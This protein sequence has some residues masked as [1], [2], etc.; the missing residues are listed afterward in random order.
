MPVPFGLT[1]SELDQLLSAARPLPREQRR[2]FVEAVVHALALVERAEGAEIGDG[3]VYCV[4]AE[5][6]RRYVDALDAPAAGR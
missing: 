4:A 1:D 3:V 6:Q 2:A 5:I